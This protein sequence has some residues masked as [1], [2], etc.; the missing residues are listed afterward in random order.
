[1]LLFLVLVGGAAAVVF[2]VVFRPPGMEPLESKDYDVAFDK[3]TYD[4]V[5]SPKKDVTHEYSLIWLHGLNKNTRN[6]FEYFAEQEE[7][8]RLTSLNTK[9]LI[10]QAGKMKLSRAPPPKKDGYKDGSPDRKEEGPG[11]KKGGRGGKDGLVNS[12]F[13]ILEGDKPGREKTEAD[14]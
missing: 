8:E 7:G 6:E 9:I 11:G 13:D 12:W 14:W 1:M 2:L 4:I 3:E 5:L 10:P